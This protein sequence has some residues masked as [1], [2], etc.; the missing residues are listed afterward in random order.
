[1]S[2]TR[3]QTVPTQPPTT[4]GVTR[5]LVLAAGIAAL[6][7]A[8]IGAILP[9][10]PATPFILLAAYCFARSSR[11]WHRWLT[12]NRLFGRHVTHMVQ[13]RALSRPVKIAL[14]ASCWVTAALSATLLAPNLAVR[15][16]SLGI[17]AGMSAYVLLRER[18]R[19]KATLAGAPGST[20]RRSSS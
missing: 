5:V 6:G 4:T 8:V 18:R 3:S 2:E 7:L 19:P 15:L 10:M 20:V 17:A 14:I 13:G 16:S 12:E 1:M 11:R 9:V